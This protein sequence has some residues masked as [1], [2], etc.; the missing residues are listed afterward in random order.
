MINKPELIPHVVGS[1]WARSPITMFH[2]EAEA[3]TFSRC[4]PVHDHKVK[5][6]TYYK[7]RPVPGHWMAQS[8]ISRSVV[9]T[10]PP[11]SSLVHRIALK[12]HLGRAMTMKMSRSW[13]IFKLRLSQGSDCLCMRPVH[14][15][16]TARS[17]K[18]LGNIRLMR[19]CSLKKLVAYLEK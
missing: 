15:F 18:M 1:Q 17:G 19:P 16:A 2:Q 12:T 6:V 7:S 10:Y 14:E 11:R 5:D 13:Q 3:S 4:H 9:G 8:G